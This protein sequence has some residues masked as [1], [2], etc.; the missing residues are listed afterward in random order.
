[1]GNKSSA[2]DKHRKE[3]GDAEDQAGDFHGER[4]KTARG[5]GLQEEK[6]NQSRGEALGNLGVYRELRDAHRV[7]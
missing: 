5:G 6:V 3:A 7:G 4:R 1:M 2:M